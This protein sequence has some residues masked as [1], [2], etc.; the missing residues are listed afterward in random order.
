MDGGIEAKDVEAQSDAMEPD[1]SADAD[2]RHAR[3]AEYVND[4]LRQSRWTRCCR[5]T[6]AWPGL[7]CSAS[8]P[9][10]LRRRYW[11]DPSPAA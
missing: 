8:T 10:M 3:I 6:P 4:E 2:L 11:L 7:R 1:E 9:A 5:P